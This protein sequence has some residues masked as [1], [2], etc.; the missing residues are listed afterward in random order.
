MGPGATDPKLAEIADK[1]VSILARLW[2]RALHRSRLPAIPKQHVFQSSPGFGAGRYRRINAI[3]TRAV[4]FNPRPALGP[5]ATETPLDGVVYD[6]V[7]ILARLWGRA[8]RHADN[9]AFPGLNRFNPRPAL[10]PGATIVSFV[11]SANLHSFNPRP[12]LGPGA[13][14]EV[15]N[16]HSWR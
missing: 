13:T 9:I 5:G 11:L 1:E 2:G 6:D 3:K 15:E 4:G 16:K 10:G 7:S 14:G 12:A 8:L